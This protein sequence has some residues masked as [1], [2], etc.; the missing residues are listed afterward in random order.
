MIT[1]KQN[2]ETGIVTA[3]VFLILAAVFKWDWPYIYVVT[4]ILMVSVLA[5]FLFTPLSWVWF[6]FA[7]VAEKLFSSVILLLVF[8]L[9]LTPVSWIR[10]VCTRSD[11]L[12]LRQF[13][14]S[15]ESVFHSVNHTYR[16]EDMDHQF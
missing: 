14:K 8:Y 13:K 1:Q 5:P 3:I 6:R 15:R 11:L 16:A 10:N 12:R 2:T 7:S 4:G 9:V